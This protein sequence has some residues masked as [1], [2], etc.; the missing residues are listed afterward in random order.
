MLKDGQL[1]ELAACCSRVTTL[2]N[3]MREMRFTE[4]PEVVRTQRMHA[5]NNETDV[6]EA[7]R[8]GAKQLTKIL[9]HCDRE[10]MHRILPEL[11]EPDDFF[12][13]PPDDDDGDDA[14]DAIADDSNDHGDDEAGAPPPPPPD[15]HGADDDGGHSHDDDAN[16]GGHGHGS[17]GNGNGNDDSQLQSTTLGHGLRK[18]CK[19]EIL[20]R[21][22]RALLVV[23]GWL[24]LIPYEF[25]MRACMMMPLA[26]CTHTHTD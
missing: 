16:E 25:M 6:R 22:L 14:K 5:V 1:D 20:Q 15:D 21:H 18:S 3:M 8:A 19:V 2:L 10:T 11:D 17:D 7:N 26:S 13:P 4:H 9:F 24:C 23:S 12:P